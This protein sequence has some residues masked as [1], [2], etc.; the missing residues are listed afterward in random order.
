MKKQLLLACLLCVSGLV[1]A[2]DAVGTV[3]NEG[4]SDLLIDPVVLI[5]GPFFHASYER[6]LTKD[7]G[8]GVNTLLLLG[9][10]ALEVDAMIS[11]YARMYMG[12]DHAHG[13][14][15][16]VSLPVTTEER[17]DGRRF[18]GS[19]VRHTNV[20]FGVGAGG[21]WI[22]KNNLVLELGGAL[23]RRFFYDGPGEPIIGKWMIGLGYRF[24]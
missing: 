8:V 13:F 9:S 12:M 6:L 4:K 23:G 16:E 17:E 22:V 18:G 19:M 7:Y 10:G 24:K 15:V 1:S 20:G 21:K 11:P 3:S 14:F 5:A 2:Q